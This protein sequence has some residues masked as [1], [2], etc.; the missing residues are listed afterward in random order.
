MI[1][2]SEK[3]VFIVKGLILL[4]GFLKN[5]YTPNTNKYTPNTKNYLPCLVMGGRL[6]LGGRDYIRIRRKGLYSYYIYTIYIYI[7]FYLDLYGRF[8]SVFKRTHA[9]IIISVVYWSNLYVLRLK[10]LTLSHIIFPKISP[11]ISREIIF[12]LKSG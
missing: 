12:S 7:H 6:V 1:L 3:I 5:K 10:L 9:N 11:F 2:R 4:K 8:S